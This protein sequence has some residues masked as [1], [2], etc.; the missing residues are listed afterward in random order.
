MLC[1]S[2]AIL[3]RVCDYR[4][5]T[6]LASLNSKR[7]LREP[8]KVYRLSTRDS[9]LSH[10]QEKQTQQR[11]FQRKYFLCPLSCS[12]P[13]GPDTGTFHHDCSGRI[14]C[15]RHLGNQKTC[16]AS[17]LRCPL[18]PHKYGFV[19]SGE[20]MNRIKSQLQGSLTNVVFRVF[21]F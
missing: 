3:V 15:L 2:L 6:S 1:R 17:T 21:R 19:C 8:W 13:Q 18:S 10:P 7:L 9:K 20:G 16:I 14:K 5:Q 11:T 4:K 12:V